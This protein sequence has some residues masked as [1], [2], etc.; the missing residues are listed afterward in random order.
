M[1]RPPI[2]FKDIAAHVSVRLIVEPTL[3]FYQVVERIKKYF[4][5]LGGPATF[6]Q[7]LLKINSAANLIAN[8]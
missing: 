8:L 4:D 7:V 6:I 2:N 1:S 5:I 3:F